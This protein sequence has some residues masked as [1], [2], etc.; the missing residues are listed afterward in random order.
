MDCREAIYGE[1]T[2]EFFIQRY[3]P[4]EEI[5]E[6]YGFDC[7]KPVNSDYAVAYLQSS[8]LTSF[9]LGFANVYGA[10]PKC[11]A[12]TNGGR[13][14]S[15]AGER[16]SAPALEAIGVAQLRRLPYLDLYGNGVMIGFV[17]TGIDYTHPAFRNSDGTSR[18]YSIW[19]QTVQDG[20]PP[21][22][23]GYGQEYTREDINRAL[24]SPEPA[25]QV[26]ETDE[27]GHGTFVAGVAAGNIEREDGFSGVAPQAD[28]VM[29]KLKQ[30]KQYLRDL[31]FIPPGA[32]CY[33]E[34]DLA[35][36]VEYLAKAA[37]RANKPLVICVT[38]GTNS[39]GHDGA[40]ILD[41]ILDGYAGGYNNCVIASTGGEAGYGLHYH[42]LGTEGEY[43]EVELRVGEMEQGFTMEFWATS[44]NQYSVS[45]ISPTGELI[46]REM[47]RRNHS[48]T[49]NFLFEDTRIFLDYFMA[50]TRSGTQLIVMRVQRPTPGIWRFLVYQDQEFGG[51]FDIW[52]PV[53]DFLQED[54]YF[55][56]PNP[57]ITITDPGNTHRLIT[58]SSYRISDRSLVT[59]GT[60]PHGDCII[61]VHGILIGHITNL[62]IINHKGIIQF[63]CLVH[64]LINR[65]TATAFHLLSRCMD[66][67]GIQS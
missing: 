39:G 28:I 18:I 26:P 22:D 4:L 38:L 58:A 43:E 34:T 54:T 56:R 66:I 17:D 14:N 20:T 41:E 3:R 59:S 1:N 8:R 46:S 47:N 50:E 16:D 33:Q 48:Q 45:V 51:S 9:G 29:V 24:A 36:G 61:A 42:S 37:A 55:L 63:L 27:S 10:V 7:I 60:N 35:F 62:V 25:E 32:E 52:L 44:L 53:H 5:K 40:G 6:K 64:H 11:Y 23:F 12:L 30:A 65:G 31:Y 13:E 67:N 2:V 49:M 19:D 15:L 21:D 57:D